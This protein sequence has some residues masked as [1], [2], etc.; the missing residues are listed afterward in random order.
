MIP[1]GF[2]AIVVNQLDY[3]R[4]VKAYMILLNQWLTSTTNSLVDSFPFYFWAFINF[5]GLRVWSCLSTEW[6][7]QTVLVFV[8][9]YLAIS[10]TDYLRL[11]VTWQVERRRRDKINNWIV[12]LSKLIPECAE[13]TAAAST[14]VSCTV[15]NIPSDIMGAAITYL[16]IIWVPL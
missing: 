16:V 11:V 5:V 1:R 10:Q 4:K 9:S 13:S 12:S 15:Y 3:T 8:I 6:Q 7:L 14:V 2:L